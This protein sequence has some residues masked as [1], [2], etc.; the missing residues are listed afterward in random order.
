L[1]ETGTKE[2]ARAFGEV[3]KLVMIIINVSMFYFHHHLPLPLTPVPPPPPRAL[4]DMFIILL[5]R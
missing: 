3:L 1:S 2:Q 5:G 4:L